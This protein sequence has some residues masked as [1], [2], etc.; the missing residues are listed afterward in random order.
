MK[1]I[2]EMFLTRTLSEGEYVFQI[3]LS[4]LELSKLKY[5]KWLDLYFAK[6]KERFLKDL[7][8]VLASNILT[9]LEKMTDNEKVKN[10]L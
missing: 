10:D 6:S 2:H 9:E 5:H 8:E 3:R 4:D 1:I 7:S